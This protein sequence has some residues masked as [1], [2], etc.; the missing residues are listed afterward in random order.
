MK[1]FINARDKRTGKLR[2]LAGLRSRRERETD[3]LLN[4]WLD[5]DSGSEHGEITEIEPSVLKSTTGK[6]ATV[7][8]GATLLAGIPLILESYSASYTAYV[9]I[10]INELLVQIIG[11]AVAFIAVILRK[12]F[13]LNV[14]GSFGSQGSSR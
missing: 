12:R 3:I 2:P 5:N 4:G 14:L 6:F 9:D 11:P 13:E 8:L 7:G 1:E 10:P